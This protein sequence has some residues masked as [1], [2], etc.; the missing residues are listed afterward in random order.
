MRIRLLASL[1]VFIVFPALPSL[2]QPTE[3]ARVAVLGFQPLADPAWTANWKIF[4]DALHE[5]GWT[6]GRNLSLALHSTEGKG[7]RNGELAARLVEQAPNV[8]VSFYYPS[9]QALA[10][11]TKTIPIVMFGVPNP[12]GL[13]LVASLSRPGG[14][15]TGVSI[16]TEDTLGKD[17]QLLREIGPRISHVAV[18]TYGRAPYW[19]LAQDAYTAAA[20]PLGLAL[21]LIPVSKPADLDAALTTVAKERP[22]AL[23]VSSLPLFAARTPAIAAFAIEHRL[24]TF[25]FQT[26]MARDGL[27]MSYEA[28]EPEM[29]RT[30]AAIT[31]KILRGARPADIPV[32]QPTTFRLTINMKTARAI[33][34]KI[35]PLLLAQVDNAVQ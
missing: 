1:L 10:Q 15:I 11:R 2:A 9:T 32:E 13:G 21:H 25:T 6:E 16:Q 17:L 18:L 20:Q 34:I 30:A 5:R 8:I 33:G 28:D 27:L 35:P 29:L 7:E 31:D 12:V 23:V 3:V 14:N 19:K 4:T 22:D 26:Q 24:P